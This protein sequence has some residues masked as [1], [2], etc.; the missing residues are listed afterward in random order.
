MFELWR[1]TYK[2]SCKKRK[3]N[4][5]TLMH[6]QFSVPGK[7]VCVLLDKMI[8]KSAS[9]KYT[10]LKAENEALKKAFVMRTNENCVSGCFF[11][12]A[13]LF[14]D[15]IIYLHVLDNMKN[16]IQQWYKLNI[17]QCYFFPLVMTDWFY[18][19]KINRLASPK[20]VIE[21][22]KEKREKKWIIKQNQYLNEW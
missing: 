11:P 15:A 22:Q 18:F 7:S 9:C 14:H 4:K 21:S 17:N 6:T 1:Y 10:L 13:S 2:S 16:Y 19:V 20:W 8:E 5:N 3:A 12:V